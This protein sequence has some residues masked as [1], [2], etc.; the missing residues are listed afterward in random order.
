M[1]ALSAAA[2]LG[3]CTRASDGTPTADTLGAAATSDT[4]PTAAPGT[5]IGH[6]D[7]G[8]VETTTPVPT[9]EVTCSPEQRP[10]VGMVAQIADSVAPVLTIAV[11]QGWSMQGGTGDIGAQLTGPNG[12]TATVTIV[13]TNLDP[14]QAFA[15]YAEELTGDAAVSSLNVLPAP[16]CGYSGQKMTGARSDTPADAVEFVDRVAHIPTASRTYLVS[17]HTAAPSLTGE[18]DT[19]AQQLTGDFEVRIP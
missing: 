10:A 15:E 5:G 3:G 7:F 4:V 16:L 19:A 6:P 9:G 12:M 13:P 1:A 18:F 17:V 14:Q 11:P 2:L 8:I